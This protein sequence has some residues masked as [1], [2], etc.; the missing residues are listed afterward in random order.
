MKKM[1][2]YISTH[3]SRLRKKVL[4]RISAWYQGL[5]IVYEC[6]DGMCF[7]A[8]KNVTNDKKKHLVHIGI[9]YDYKITHN[10]NV[11]LDLNELQKVED[12]YWE[13]HKL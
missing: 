13:S 8:D 12:L 10:D 4:S 7:V 9:V 3:L 1:F 11:Y 2:N 5:I 6:K